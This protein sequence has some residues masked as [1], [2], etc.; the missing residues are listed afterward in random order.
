MNYQPKKIGE[1]KELK[2]YLDKIF[3]D[4]PIAYRSNILG[5]ILLLIGFLFLYNPT[6]ITL[7]I[8]VV[9]ILIGIFMIFIITGKKITKGINESQITSMMI[10]WVLVIFFITKEARFDIFFV[11]IILGALMIN[12]LTH[13]FTTI[14]I[15]NRLNILIFGFIIIFLTI[16]VQKIINFLNI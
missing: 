13:E 1:S 4:K 3:F 14:Q 5:V 11:L 10:I 16:M 9:F 2:R 7:K 12:E 8:G 15:K 6:S